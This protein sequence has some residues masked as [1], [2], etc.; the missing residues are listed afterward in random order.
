MGLFGVI[1][2]IIQCG[3]GNFPKDSWNDK[4][5]KHIIN[6][7]NFYYNLTNTY[8]EHYIHHKD[9]DLKACLWRYVTISKYGKIWIDVLYYNYNWFYQHLNSMISHDLFLNEWTIW[10]CFVAEPKESKENYQD[11][12]LRVFDIKS[13]VD[14]AYI[15]NN[16]KLSNLDHF[17]VNSENKQHK[18][19]LSHIV[20]SSMISGR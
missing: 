9:F 13:P 15:W 16:H 10:F 14:L 5:K 17:F 12:Y 2:G 6:Y 3:D 11:N 20:I 19:S 7:F 1:V 8:F 4:T 18:Y